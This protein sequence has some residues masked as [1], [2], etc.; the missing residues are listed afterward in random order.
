MMAKGGSTEDVWVVTFQN[1]YSGELEEVTVS[2]LKEGNNKMSPSYIAMNKQQVIDV[3]KQDSGL[4][5]DWQY[6]SA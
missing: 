5:S 3:A 2:T 6:Y 1:Q 4:S